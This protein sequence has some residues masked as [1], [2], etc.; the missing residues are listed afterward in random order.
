MKQVVTNKAGTLAVIE[1][2]APAL[3]PGF[4]R[5]R[6]RYS[7]ISAGTEGAQVREGK[8]GLLTKAREH[9]DQVR[10]VLAKVKKEGVKATFAQVRDKLDQWRTL[11][12]SLGGNVLEVGAGVDGLAAG[13]PVACAGAG[14]AVHAEEVV[15]PRHLVA[16]V[17]DGVDLRH[18]A[19]VTLGAIALHGVRRSEPALGE[20]ALVVGLGLVGQ[21]AVQL[22]AASGARVAGLDPDAAR[23]ELAKRLGAELVLE[24]GEDPVQ[25][26][27]TWTAGLGV[28]LALLCAATASS[29]PVH[30]A[31]RVLRDRG[32][33]VV[34]GDVGLELERDPFYRKELD[35]TLSR[36]Y[37]PGR[38]DPV[39]E[40]GGVDYPAGYVR[41]TEGRNLEAVLDLLARGSLH[42]EPLIS[43]EA[44]LDEAPSVYERLLAGG[45]ALGTLLRYEPAAGPAPRTLALEEAPPVAGVPG[46]LLVGGG[47]YART[48]H[49]PN[50]LRTEG[51]R[52]AGVVT[53]TGA[54]A[55][56]LAEKGDGAFAGT[57]L[58]E[59]LGR[60][61][62]DAV[63]LCTRHHLHVP[64]ALAAIR[65][66]KH[67]LVEKPLALDAEGLRALAA[68]LRQNPVRLAVGFNR[69]LAPLAVLLKEQV[70]SSGGPLHGVYRMNG[71]RLPSDHWVQ[72]P[73]QGGGRVVGEGCHAFDFFNFLTGSEPRTVQADAVQSSDPAVRADDNLTATVRYADGSV[74][75]LLYTTAAPGGG[76]K[77]VVEVFGPGLAAT[78]VDFRE[79][80]W[81]GTSAGRKRLPREDKGQ[82]ATM[83]A[84]SSYLRGEPAP[85]V[86]FPE[87]ASSTWLT[88]R[89]VEASRTGTTLEVAATLS[90]LLGA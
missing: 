2:P 74:F 63:L 78:L 32:R 51:L 68:A 83:K 15:V 82:A 8:A 34:V 39:Y 64:Q 71:G 58:D 28:D 53:R 23:S 75:T 11:G 57:D 16:R 55:R 22:L 69:R 29:D 36:S 84:W 31:S 87:A 73:A 61:G 40:E 49:L 65:A 26:L 56:E 37:G 19:F 42:V 25:R 86:A 12:Y 66:G 35:F 88:L 46:V 5:V 7:L 13:D 10:Q 41:W 20:R 70:A 47:W 50:L 1:V 4:V 43:E 18:A 14:Y 81:S 60:T 48:H 52:L 17:P 33:V 6:T 21:L 79:L 24:A 77:E 67:V 90:G 80:T 72:D 54:A 30:T 27:S 59:A 45:G 44:A 85:V 89:A 76:S 9:P 38:Y 62:V 3:P